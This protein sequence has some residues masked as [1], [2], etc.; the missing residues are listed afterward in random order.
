MHVSS[1]GRRH[2]RPSRY[3][4]FASLPLRPK[5]HCYHRIRAGYCKRTAAGSQV[6]ISI[7]YSRQTVTDASTASLETVM[8]KKPVAAFSARWRTSVRSGAE[9]AVMLAS[10]TLSRRFSSLGWAVDALRYLGWRVANLVY[11]A[12]WP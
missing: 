8:M 5:R 6:R 12:A 9:L 3:R 2:K 10:V 4:R 1:R 11:P 7:P